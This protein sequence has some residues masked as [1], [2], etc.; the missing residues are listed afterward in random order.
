[1]YVYSEVN[2]KVRFDLTV[3]YLHRAGTHRLKGI[4]FSVFE[5]FILSSTLKIIIKLLSS[6]FKLASPYHPPPM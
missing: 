3:L 2:I 5:L 6:F 1:M 4:K